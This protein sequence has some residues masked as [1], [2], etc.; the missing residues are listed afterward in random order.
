[1]IKKIL[2]LCKKII[3]G[4]MLLFVYNTFLSSLNIIIPFNFITLIIVSLLDVPGIIGLV[5]I[6]LVY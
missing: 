3:I 1:M 6:L 4:L 2:N 5:L